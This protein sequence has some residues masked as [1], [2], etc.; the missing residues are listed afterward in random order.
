M[1]LLQSQATAGRRDDTVSASRRLTKRD[2]K[3]PLS[4]LAWLA[5]IFMIVTT[6]VPFIVTL[7]YSVHEWN[8]MTPGEREFVGLDNFR[9]VF[10]LDGVAVS[11]WNTTRMTVGALVLAVGLG[12]VLAL[13]LN[14]RFRGR[15]VVRTMIFSAFL[16]PPAAAALTWKTTMLDPN[17]GLVGFLLGTD[18]DWIANWP[19]A[20][21]VAVTAWQWAPFAMLIIFAGLQN[22]DESAKEAAMTDGAGP[23]RVFW[24]ITLPHLRPHIE[25]TAL[26]GAIFISQLLDPI[27]LITQGG[28]GNATTTAAYK[29]H[30]LAFKSFDVGLASAFG[31]VV[32]FLTI[33]TTLILL[34]LAVKSIREELR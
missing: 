13:L 4:P 5:I 21:I 14:R 1:A 33:V 12:L 8:L 9:E 2:G 27:F 22:Q 15:A 28:P 18:A 31:V 29:L 20:V 11:L 25:V 10:A 7:W 19:M 6:Q 34:R 16:V 26:L 32:V 17:Y 3:F 24:H 23:L 30:S